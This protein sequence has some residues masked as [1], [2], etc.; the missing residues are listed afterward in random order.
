[1]FLLV[2]GRK[3]VLALEDDKEW[4]HLLYYINALDYYYLLLIALLDTLCPS[5]TLRACKY[6]AY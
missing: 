3:V 4:N 2:L 5:S 6:C 1:M